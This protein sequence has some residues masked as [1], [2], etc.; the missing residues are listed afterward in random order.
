MTGVKELEKLEKIQEKKVKKKKAHTE[1]AKEKGD[2]RGIEKAQAE[3]DKAIAVLERIRGDK[4]RAEVEDKIFGYVKL[5]Q[6][7][8]LE[9]IAKA[10]NLSP[11]TIEEHIEMSGMVKDEEGKIFS[12]EGMMS[13][14]K[15]KIKSEELVKRRKDVIKKWSEI[16]EKNPGL[17]QE[18]LKPEF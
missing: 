1:R 15:D 3:E 6:P 2:S 10:L 17:T 13:S 11:E 7:A 9:E 12:D 14:I 8:E 18:E 16:A 4:R 5:N